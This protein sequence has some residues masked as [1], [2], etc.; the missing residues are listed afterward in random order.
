MM[1]LAAGSTGL[2]SCSD[3]YAQPPV[4]LPEGGIGTGAW[5]NP[6]TAYQCRIGSVNPD[7]SEA[8]VT[9]YIV[10]V[11]NTSVGNV[12]N[13][14]CAQ[15][16]GPFTTNTNLIIAMTPDET[17]WENCATVQLPSGGVRDALNL[18][19][20][21]DNLGKQVTIKGTT[22]EKYCGAYGI[23]SASDY[24]W[25]DKGNEEV[26]LPPADG[27][28]YVDWEASTS[29]STYEA[30]GWKNVMVSGG[31]SGWYINDFNGNHYIATSAYKGTQTGGPYENWLIS[32]AIDLSKLDTKTLEFITQAAYPAE[33][34]TLEVYAMTS[35]NP[36][37]STNTRLQ[38]AIATPPA[39]GGGGSPYSDWLNS[40]KI[41]LSHFSGTIYIGWR[42]YSAQGSQGY[43]STYCIDNV[44]VGN[45]M[46]STPDT[47]DTP[48]N[49][50]AQP[51]TIYEGL[52]VSETSID[53]TFDNIQLPAGVTTVWSWKEYSGK[54]YLNGSAFGGSAQDCVAIAYSPAISLTGVTGASVEFDH[55]AKFQK[56]IAT[57][58]RFV[59]REKGTSDWTEMEIPQWPKVDT[60]TFS[61]SGKI[62][63]SAFDGKEV[64][65]GFK[66]VSSTAGADTWEIRNVKVTGKK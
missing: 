47:P 34:S 44:N 52:G 32:P 48:D 60:W 6:M 35:D 41:D 8:W 21:P 57:L 28:F 12:L 3:D 24:N 4:V 16:E 55:A 53:W 25:G 43:S 1:L 49:P 56:T 5:D 58:G 13:A 45:A 19:S 17:N 39:S 33:N 11:V 20:N 36:K 37:K 64:E 26:V 30:M 61:S 31:L 54:Y 9:G 59:V 27:P 18:V 38:A 7:R 42:Y 22:G 46:P 40:G 2:V 23:R 62:D 14:R 29:F 15:F 50:P 65:I 63:I 51:G 10:G 66:Y